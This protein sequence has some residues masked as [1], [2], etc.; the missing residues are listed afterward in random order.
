MLRLEGVWKSFPSNSTQYILRDCSQIFE[1]SSIYT[2]FGESGVGKTT[3]LRC[4]NNLDSISRGRILLEGIT[5]ESIPPATVRRKASLLF[6]TPAFVGNT[7]RENFEFVAQCQ[8]AADYS[9]ESLLNRVQLKPDILDRPVVSLSVGQQQRI[10]LARLLIGKPQV[11]LL[12]EPTAALDDPTSLRILSI[13]QD[14]AGANGMT[15]IMVTHRREHA[16]YLGG[17]QL[18]LIDGKLEREA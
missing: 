2:I 10:C 13:I 7:A 18:A 6:Q 5:I 8:A 16:E 12:D 14:L 17:Q 15:V 9:P 3:L 1:P 4:L 11:L